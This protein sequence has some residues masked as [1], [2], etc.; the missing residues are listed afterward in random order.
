VPV[1]ELASRLDLAPEQVAARLDVIS[2]QLLEARAP[3]V[4]PGLDDKWLTSWNALLIAGLAEAGRW[5]QRE[6]WSA[7]AAR[8]YAALRARLRAADGRW[9]ACWRSGS[10]AELGPYLDD[11]AYLLAAQLELLSSAGTP[12]LLA[13]AAAIADLLLSEFADPAGA[14]WFTAHSAEALP[15]RPKSFTDEATPNGNGVAIRALLRLGRLLG[16]P[17]WL[18]AAEAGLSAGGGELQ[19]HPDACASMLGALTEAL[20][21]PLELVWRGPPDALKHWQNGLRQAERAGWL[22]YRLAD[23]EQPW[24]G[25]LA[26]MQSTTDG[27]AWLCRASVCELPIDTPEALSTRVSEGV[28]ED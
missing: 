23:A 17:R 18:Q 19:R 12:E 2:A 14:F 5:L 20:T 15:A 4:R 3:R 11:H 9:W 13:D 7:L 10:R 1:A 8:T 22:V 21:P 26:A 6:D 27:R 16:E 25:V 28:R 24:P